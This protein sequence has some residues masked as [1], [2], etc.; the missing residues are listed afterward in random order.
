MQNDFK[1]IHRKVS[2]GK[3]SQNSQQR[4]NGQKEKRMQKGSA[5][6]L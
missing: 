6:F 1:K 3:P 5:E 4:H 2:A